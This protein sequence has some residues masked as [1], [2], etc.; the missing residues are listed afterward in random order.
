M[1]M[2]GRT[3]PVKTC[4][5]LLIIPHARVAARHRITLQV[6]GFDVRRFAEWNG[7]ALNFDP[8]VVIVQ[9]PRDNGSAADIGTR[10]RARAR[11]SPLILLGLSPSSSFESER[12]D[13]RHS[14]FDDVFPIDVEPTTLLSRLQHLLS[15]RPPL[16]P[17]A[18][19]PAA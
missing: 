5:A 2:M 18:T 12:R 1:D 16:T 17:C 3:A 15:V 8:E 19:D 10:L 4:V 9:L 6:A 14:G 11:F 13:G 7:D